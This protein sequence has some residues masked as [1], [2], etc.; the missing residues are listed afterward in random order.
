LGH[1]AG[2]AGGPGLGS[3]RTAGGLARP[4]SGA[5]RS[6]QPG[7]RSVGIAARRPD[8]TAFVGPLPMLMREPVAALH[9]ESFV[10]TYTTL[11]DSTGGRRG[12]VGTVSA[13]GGEDL[14]GANFR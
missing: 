14:H 9:P 3:G 2:A 4:L 7:P 12:R 11:R 10:R 13:A 6:K 5:P 8:L 1:A